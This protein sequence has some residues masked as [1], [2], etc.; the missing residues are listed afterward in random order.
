MRVYYDLAI[1][2]SFG[3]RLIYWRKGRIWFGLPRIQEEQWTFHL[4]LQ[5][6]QG[7]SCE[8][9][10]TLGIWLIQTK[11]SHSTDRQALCGQRQRQ[12]NRQCVCCVF[13]AICSMQRFQHLVPFF[14][15]RSVSGWS[16]GIWILFFHILG[17]IIPIVFIFFRGVDTTNQ[18]NSVYQRCI[19]PA[20]FEYVW[21]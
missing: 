12:T 15:K 11:H 20:S 21:T 16:F 14:D 4:I 8:N 19:L 17:T 1:R 13:A 10:R 7:I 6:S 2:I 18:V 3:F 5:D 9:Q